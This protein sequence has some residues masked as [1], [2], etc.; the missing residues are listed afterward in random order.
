MSG[1]KLYSD[2]IEVNPPLIVYAFVVLKYFAQLTGIRDLVLFQYTVFTISLISIYLTY[3]IL[4]LDITKSDRFYI[5]SLCFLLL[6]LFTTGNGLMFGQREHL[7][8]MLCLPYLFMTALRCRDVRFTGKISVI[9]GVMAGLGIAM[10][11]FF[12]PAWLAIEIYA[13]YFQSYLSLKRP[14]HLSLLTVFIVY[15]LCILIFTPDYIHIAF[16]YIDIYRGY[17]TS[18]FATLLTQNST[19]IAVLVIIADAIIPRGPALKHIRGLLSVSL[20]MFLLAVFL[21]DKGWDYHWICV[22]VITCILFA[23]MM[24]DGSLKLNRIT[25]RTLFMKTTAGL[26][27]ALS[28]V[29]SVTDHYSVRKRWDAMANAPYYLSDFIGLVSKYIPHGTISSLSPTVQVVWPLINYTGIKWGSRYNNMW[30]IPGIFHQAGVSPKAFT[31]RPLN[32]VSRTERGFINNVID[33]LEVNQPGLLIVPKLP[34]EPE[35]KGFSYIAYFS[36]D[37]RFRKIFNTYK[38]AGDMDVYKIYVKKNLK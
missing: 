3:R 8:V 7:T 14:E 4:S 28:V 11:P 1:K 10:K 18:D 36:R 13:V 21:Q 22:H 24:I 37:S 2:I 17:Y 25:G 12:I 32:T 23:V 5:A 35:M 9:T 29:I 31:Y 15:A 27:I 26:I 38:S 30:L 6:Y 33:D 34:P 20:V 19:L 16:K